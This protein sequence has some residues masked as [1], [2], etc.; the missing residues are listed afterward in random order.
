MRFANDRSHS[1][2]GRVHR[3]QASE[4]AALVTDIL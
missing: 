2:V 4:K 1:F 3:L